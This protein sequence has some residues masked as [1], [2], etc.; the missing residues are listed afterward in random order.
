MR[1]IVFVLVL[2]GGAIA[3]T[4]L[5]AHLLLAGGSLVAITL[6]RAVPLLVAVLV[7]GVVMVVAW[8]IR[9][10]GLQRWQWDDDM[11]K[12]QALASAVVVLVYS[13]FVLWL[14]MMGVVLKPLAAW[15]HSDRPPVLAASIAA[16]IVPSV[17]IAFIAY[18][19]ARRFYTGSV[20][21][22]DE[23]GRKAR[24]TARRV[25]WSIAGAAVLLLAFLTFW[26][27][28]DFGILLIAFFAVPPA[29]LLAVIGQVAKWAGWAFRSAGARTCGKWYL[30]LSLMWVSV[31]LSYP[32]GWLLT[33]WQ[34][35]QS[36]SYC[37]RLVPELEAYKAE[38]GGYPSSISQVTGDRKPPRKLRRQKIGFYYGDLG[39]YEFHIEDQRQFFG[40][41]VYSSGSP[42]WHVD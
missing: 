7:A 22:D 24:L 9:K 31:G 16:A 3:L 5:A 17:I 13:C 19:C 42:K 25:V 2:G 28:G 4:V 21:G 20:A 39:Q 38:H 23:A 29:I 32:A 41:W 34:V 40:F 8:I 18:W 36:K 33:E 27:R 12:V 35:D 11:M 1:I 10:R 15:T 6:A 14:P 30:V 37:Q 26:Y